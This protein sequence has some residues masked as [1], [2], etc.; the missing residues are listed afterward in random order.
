MADQ[1]RPQPLSIDEIESE[2]KKKPV[3]LWSSQPI[4]TAVGNTGW[5]LGKSKTTYNR[6]D[7]DCPDGT[8]VGAKLSR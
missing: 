8:T 2:Q 4:P 7:E 5:S 1:D 3:K 6:D